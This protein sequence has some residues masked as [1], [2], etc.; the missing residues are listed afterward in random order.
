[1][2]PRLAGTFV[3]GVE[4][5]VLTYITFLPVSTRLVQVIAF[6]TDE[7]YDELSTRVVKIIFG[8]R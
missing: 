3:L 1:M 7:S 4:S 8:A 2:S 5:I 6:E